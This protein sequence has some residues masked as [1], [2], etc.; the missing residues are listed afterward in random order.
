MSVAVG[1]LLL[2]LLLLLEA[3]YRARELILCCS[4]Q[5]RHDVGGKAF[6]GSA[7]KRSP[8]AEPSALP[9]RNCAATAEMTY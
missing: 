2:L 1:C 9:P 5:S 6:T 4:D 3:L 7:G 8:T